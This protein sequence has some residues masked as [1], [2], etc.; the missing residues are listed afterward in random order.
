LVIDEDERRLLELRSILKNKMSTLAL[1]IGTNRQ[2]KNTIF[3]PQ[4]TDHLLLFV[5]VEM[6]DRLLINKKSL[7]FPQ[8]LGFFAQTKPKGHLVEILPEQAM[9]TGDK[10]QRLI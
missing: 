5:R 3:H 1:M 9:T 4:K 7:K 8:T 6:N 10:C 2:N